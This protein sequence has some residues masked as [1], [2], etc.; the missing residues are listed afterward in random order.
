MQVFIPNEFR[1]QRDQRVRG[2]VL[3]PRQICA[4]LNDFPASLGAGREKLTTRALD[5]LTDG[6]VEYRVVPRRR[7]E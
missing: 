5:E 4:R 2:G 6:E 1:T 3:V 7:T